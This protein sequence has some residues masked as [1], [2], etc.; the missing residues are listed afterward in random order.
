M[1]YN[2]G[3][4]GGLV[5]YGVYLIYDT[6]ILMGG[7]GREMDFDNYILGALQ[8]YVDIVQ[9]FLKILKLLQ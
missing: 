2:L 9:I 3:L 7:K 6:Q 4:I 8:I 5:L 1:L